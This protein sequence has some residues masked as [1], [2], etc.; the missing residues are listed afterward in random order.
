MTV[1]KHR[2]VINKPRCY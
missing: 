1:C 2:R